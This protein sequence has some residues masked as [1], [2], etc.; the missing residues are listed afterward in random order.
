MAQANPFCGKP[1]KDAS[2]HLQ[3]FL[4]ICS[5]DTMKGVSPDAVRIRLFPFSLLRKA[6]QWFYANCAMINTWDKCSTEFLSKF[7]PVSKTNALRGRIYGFQQTR[8]ESIPK[9]W[10]QLQEY[11]AAY[12]HNG[13]DDW[14]IHQSFYNWLTP[15]SRDHLDASAGGVFFSKTIRGAVELIEKIVSN[16]GWSEERLQSRQRGMHTIKETKMLTAKL[17]L[18]MK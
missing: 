3:Q 14:L 11:V 12:P 15:T 2:A 1:N 16:M 5:T 18:L 6:E 4:E 7:F 8:D 17:N 13:M 10:E 9:A